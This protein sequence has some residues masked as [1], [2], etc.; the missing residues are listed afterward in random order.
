MQ[1]FK[2]HTPNTEAIKA[3]LAKNTRIDV[4][5]LLKEC[6]PIVLGKIPVFVGALLL[7]L[8]G[9]SVLGMIVLSFFEITD[10]FAIEQSLQL[11]LEI[12]FSFALAPL[13]TGLLMM[14]V[15]G[16]NNKSLQPLDIMAY[17][18]RIFVLGLTSV[19][20]SMWIS[21]GMLLLVVPGIYLLIATMFV[22][23][24]IAEKRM[25]PIAAVYLSI[26]VVNNY[27]SQMALF[28]LL[29]L[30]GLFLGIATFG[31]LLIYILPMYYILKGKIYIALFGMSDK[32]DI[33]TL[34][35]RKDDATFAA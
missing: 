20:L 35:E 33:D 3:A 6:H 2:Q 8:L 18:P 15:R 19:F 30:G 9:M 21:I 13:F 5:A 28:N 12:L 10:P 32:D 34:E 27:F 14:G 25:K 31:I 16:A 1:S 11:K 17:F 29:F 26:R 7:V 22:L 4:F 23:P 24:L